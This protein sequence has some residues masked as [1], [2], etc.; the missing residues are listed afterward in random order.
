LAEAYPSIAITIRTERIRR[1]DLPAMLVVRLAGH[2]LGNHFSL[3]SQ[4]LCD[5][6]AASMHP[7]AMRSEHIWQQVR[8]IELTA[9]TRPKAIMTGT[10]GASLTDLPHPGRLRLTEPA[11]PIVAASVEARMV[12]R[13]L[14]PPMLPALQW[15]S[16]GVAMSGCGVRGA[17]GLMRTIIRRIR[18]NGF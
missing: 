8:R 1:G 5:F 10:G 12:I 15:S 4:W 3:V 6:A 14:L 17:E 13:L 2:T 9:M 7:L 18:L 11:W 16:G